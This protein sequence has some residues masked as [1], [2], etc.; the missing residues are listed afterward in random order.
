MTYEKLDFYTL[1]F[2]VRT[3]AM[4]VN[5]TTPELYIPHS[6]LLNIK[7]DLRRQTPQTR[8]IV[9]T[10]VLKTMIYCQNLV[11]CVSPDK[12]KN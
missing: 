5:P 6:A 4:N 7:Q 3:I 1:V 2:W 9:D 10:Y 11:F 8:F 12:L